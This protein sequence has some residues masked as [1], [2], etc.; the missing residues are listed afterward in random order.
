MN[1]RG[2]LGTLFASVAALTID[3]KGLVWYPAEQIALP[4]VAEGALIT[5]PAITNALGLRLLDL[6]H[7]QRLTD[8]RRI[9]DAGVTRQ[10][11][12]GMAVPEDMDQFGLQAVC[13]E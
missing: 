1:R 7:P 11:N 2:F 3:P 12:I 13:I 8:S 10:V 5:L 4:P 9:G 6:W